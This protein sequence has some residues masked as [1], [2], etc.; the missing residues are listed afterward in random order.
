MSP[1]VSKEIESAITYLKNSGSG[2]YQV[3]SKV[4]KEVKSTI[5]NALAIIF[6]SC[7]KYGYFPEELKIGCITPVFK[8]G[9]KTNISSYRPVCSLSLFSKIFERIIYDRMVNFIDKN[10]IF[11]KY[12]FGF[13][14]NMNTETALINFVDFVYKGLTAKEN[15]GAI[16]MDLSRAF[17]VMDHDI[18]QLKLNHYGF[19]GNFLSLLM[20]FIRERKYFVNINGMNS[21]TRTVNIGVPQGSTL[22]PLLFLLYVN[23]MENCSSILH[24]TLFADDTTLGYSCDN[25]QNLQNI[26]EQEVQKVTKWLAANKLLLN[27]NKTHS[28]LFTNK[29]NIPNLKVKTNNTEIE[30]INTT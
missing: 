7:I 12:Q 5:S 21:E 23:D 15:V 19:R 10:N 9:D 6:N 20:S 17:D 1:I 16:F 22:G 26:L 28:M 14:K 18:L 24:F 13:R 2:L 27:V 4:L 3:S 30:E 8:K 29:R 25:F 11:S